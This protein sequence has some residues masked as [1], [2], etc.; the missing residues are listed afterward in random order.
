[1][2]L[3]QTE[4]QGSGSQEEEQ[5]DSSQPS[6]SSQTILTSLDGNATPFEPAN[7]FPNLGAGTSPGSNVAVTALVNTAP[8][9]GGGVSP[10]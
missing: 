4:N 2:I 6:Q 7:L 10:N 3:A 8:Q 5:A 9:S 1:V